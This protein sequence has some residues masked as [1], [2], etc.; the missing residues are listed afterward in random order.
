MDETDPSLLWALGLSNQ[1]DVLT[2]MIKAMHKHLPSA[3]IEVRQGA[4]TV[5]H[6]LNVT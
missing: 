2:A 5:V 1:S 4:T 6:D 3:K